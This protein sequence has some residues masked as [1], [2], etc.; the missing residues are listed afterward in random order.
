[1]K[2]NILCLSQPSRAR[3]LARLTAV[4]KPQLEE[5]PDVAFVTKMFDKRFD[6]GSNRQALIDS[7][8]AEWISVVDDDDLVASDY[9][10][11]IYP[12]LDDDVDYI[13]FRLQL[14]V[15][16]EKQKPTIHSLRYK[17]W[18]ADQDG[19]YRDISHLNPIRR[20]LAI[21]A[22]MSGGPGEDARWSDRMRELGI[23]KKEHFVDSALYFYYFRSRK[24]D[25][26][27]PTR[28][29]TARVEP[30]H[31]PMSGNVFFTGRSKECPRCKSTATTIAGGLR[32]CNQC[33]ASWI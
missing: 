12:L 25:N 14:Y 13:G 11:K 7:S 28:T 22:K 27:P 24:D 8:S 32:R 19:F 10:S 18:N 30:V 33:G 6:L 20:S 31:D 5:F 16:G 26:E 1:M 17:C 4:L 15:D 21:Q 29:V 23:V 2:W 9:V 3:Y